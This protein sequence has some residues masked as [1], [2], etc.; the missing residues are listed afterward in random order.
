MRGLHI[1]NFVIFASGITAL[2][3]IDRMLVARR[4][5]SVSEMMRKDGLGEKQIKSV[6]DNKRQTW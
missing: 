5:L 1:A 6:I 2:C 3:A 4:N